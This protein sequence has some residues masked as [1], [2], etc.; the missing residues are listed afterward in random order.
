MVELDRMQDSKGRFA[1]RKNH[2]KSYADS[3]WHIKSIYSLFAQTG[4]N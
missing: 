2:V 3:T 4:T 1:V